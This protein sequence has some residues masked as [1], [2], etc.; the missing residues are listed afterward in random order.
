MITCIAFF[1]E[2]DQLSA[3]NMNATS[4]VEFAN[5]MITVLSNNEDQE[6]KEMTG[7]ILSTQQKSQQLMQN[8][9]RIIQDAIKGLQL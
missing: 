5:Q 9:E 1:A 4:A 8:R 7:V 3:F 2:S 6:F